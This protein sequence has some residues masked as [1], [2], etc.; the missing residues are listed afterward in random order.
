MQFKSKQK[1]YRLST[2]SFMLT[3]ILGCGSESDSSKLAKEIELDKLRTEGTIIESVTIENDKVRLRAGETQQLAATGIDSNGDT[4]EVTSELTWSSSDTSVVKINSNGLVTALKSSPTNQGIITIT[5]TTIND[6]SDEGEISVSNEAVQS[7]TLKQISPQTGPIQTCLPAKI[8]ADITYDD[9]YTSLNSVK[10]LDFTVDE[11][12]S[13]KISA[14]GTI[15]TSSPEV[16]S[17]VITGTINSIFSKLEVIAEPKNLD[18]IS[19]IVDEN[20]VSKITM[21]IGDRIKLGAIAKSVILDPDTSFDINK[22]VAWTQIGGSNFGITTE[23][24]N[25]GSLFALNS[26]VSQL[27]ASCGGKQKIIAVEVKGE[28]T[29]DSVQINDGDSLLTMQPLEFLDLTLTANYSKNEDSLNVTEFA[30]WTI[31]GSNVVDMKLFNAGT[32]QAVY[33]LTSTTSDNDT[34]LISAQYNNEITS[35]QINIE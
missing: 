8:S 7:L 16:E 3:I 2:I 4:R 22:S 31:N 13:A 25:K 10:G 9:G 21:N 14:D 6:I 12:S 24:N 26:G 17:T 15:Y 35:I 5:A 23:G 20:P 1:F 18:N 29:F 27:L 19:V 30:T 34:V 32:R 11:N 28:A 33:R